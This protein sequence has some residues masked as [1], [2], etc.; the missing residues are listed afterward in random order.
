MIKSAWNK[1]I[2]VIDTPLWLEIFFALLLI[3]RIP[4]FFEP[5]YY[6]DEMIYLA[7]GEGVRQGVPLYLSLHDN[8]PPL[9]YLTAAISGNLFVFKAILAF[10]SIITVYVF[11]K[12]VVH[13]FPTR[14]LLHKI[15]T[16]IFGVLTTIPLLE[17]NT[18]NA[19]LFMIGPVIIAFWILLSKKDTFWNLFIS[20][21]LISIAALF[22]IPAAF[23]ILGIVVFWA[24]YTKFTWSGINELI[25]KSVILGLGFAVPIGLTF[26]WYY[27]AGSFKEYLIAAFLQNFGYVSSWKRSGQEVPFLV[28][29]APLLMRAGMMFVGFAVLWLFKNKL[30]KN[31]VLISAWLLATLFAVTLSERPYP[32]Y[33]VQSVAPVAILLG[34]LG[35]LKSV[36]QSLTVIPLTLAFF[37]PFYYKFWYY[38]TASYYQRFLEFSFGKI[39]KEEYFNKFSPNINMNYKIANFLATSSTINE[40]TFVWG[41]DSSAIYSLSRRLP[42]IKY[43]ADYHVNDFADKKA[44]IGE[45]AQTLPKFIVITP[46]SFDYPELALFVRENYYIISEIDSAQ[47]WLSKNLTK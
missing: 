39:T 30:S 25:R 22:K 16:V 13:L 36:E 20:G 42:P 27:F 10:W 3:L 7:L 41:N 1:L 40:K 19:E 11:W 14:K 9:L 4:S 38:P 43:V 46:N 29:N 34:M 37:V 6:G 33:F 5:Y 2:S 23:D 18:V 21:A 47:V 17:G 24:I 35:S 32:H 8:K 31:F 15:S 45:L 28:K 12:L 26:I 44:I